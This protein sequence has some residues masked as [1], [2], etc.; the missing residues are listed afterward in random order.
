MDIF[1]FQ[2]TRKVTSVQHI[3]PF[4]LTVSLTI[5][6]TAPMKPL[7]LHIR[8]SKFVVITLHSITD[9]EQAHKKRVL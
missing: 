6:C 8:L 1:Y 5:F 9:N 3:L 7:V 4:S 2:S